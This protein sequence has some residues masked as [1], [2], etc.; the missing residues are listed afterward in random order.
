MPRAAPTGDHGPVQGP[1]TILA[2]LAMLG[3]LYLARRALAR[4]TALRWRALAGDLRGPERAFTLFIIAELGEIAFP[5][6]NPM[7]THAL[8]FCAILFGVVGLVRVIE[9][10][11]FSFLRTSTPRIVRS[12]VGW[13]STFIIAAVLLRY[14]Y[15][16]NL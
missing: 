11:F 1:V 13:I 5:G 4:Q 7:L 12:L 9:T 16:F 3:A 8:H 14:E 15:K 2:A 10:A 6:A